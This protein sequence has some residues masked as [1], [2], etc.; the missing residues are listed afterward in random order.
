[1]KMVNGTWKM[2][3]VVWTLSVAYAVRIKAS[4]SLAGLQRKKEQDGENARGKG[5]KRRGK[6]KGEE[7]R[8]KDEFPHCKTLHRVK[9]AL[10]VA[11]DSQRY[12]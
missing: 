4:S 5:K 3:R 9:A 1:M 6:A 11:S 2:R 8:S 12:R 7:G 10:R